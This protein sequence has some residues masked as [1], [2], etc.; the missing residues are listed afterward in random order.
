MRGYTWEQVAK[1]KE[2]IVREFEREQSK[3]KAVMI[4]AFILRM[5]EEYN[6]PREVTVSVFRSWGVITSDISNK[7]Y[8]ERNGL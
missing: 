3:K 2:T 6:I 5:E 8:L 1:T 4:P 7:E